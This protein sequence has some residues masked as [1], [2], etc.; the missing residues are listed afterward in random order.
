MREL[1]ERSL[2]DFQGFVREGRRKT[3]K[4]EEEKDSLGRENENT[5]LAL[6]KNFGL[7]L[8][9]LMIRE[10]G[11]PVTPE[12]EILEGRFLFSNKRYNFVRLVNTREYKYIKYNMSIYVLYKFTIPYG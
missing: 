10:E 7:D 8:I 6:P 11:I 2:D 5:G 3:P 12:V 9:S 1:V 4:R